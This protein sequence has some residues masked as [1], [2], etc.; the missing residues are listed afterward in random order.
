MI[1]IPGL[2]IK[3]NNPCI[4]PQQNIIPHIETVFEYDKNGEFIKKHYEVNESYEEYRWI[5]EKFITAILHEN[6][7]E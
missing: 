1:C 4:D 7:E 3:R 2:P 5:I 6:M